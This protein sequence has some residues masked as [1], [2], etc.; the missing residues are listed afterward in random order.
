M[1]WLRLSITTASIFYTICSVPAMI[2]P[3]PP[4]APGANCRV[5]REAI[6]QA[7]ARVLDSGW[8]V[9][10][11]EVAA[12]EEEFAG[13]VGTRHAI[14]VG[15]GTD[16]L[17]V[18]LRALG[19]GPNDAVLTVSHTAV[20]TVAAIE[21]TGATPVLLDVD[22]VTFT[23]DT[24]ALDT[25]LADWRADHNLF[26]GAAPR[27]IIPVH[28]Y[29]HPADMPEIMRVAH[30]NGLAVVED[31]AQAH[32]ATLNGRR[33]GTWGDLA[34]FSFYPT[35][36]LSAIGDGGAVVT[37]DREL[38]TRCLQLRE[39]GWQQRSSVIPGMN[40]RLDELQAAILRIKL[41]SLETENRRRV[42]IAA[43]YRH[44]LGGV[45]QVPKSRA[46]ADVGHVYHQFVIRSHQ[47]DELKRR[48]REEYGVVT[49]IHY[50][51]AIHQQ[52][53][54]SGRSLTAGRHL[55]VTESLCREILSLPVFPELEDGDL[56]RVCNAVKSIV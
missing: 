18:A 37:N 39:Y 23:I 26:G 33:V 17:V 25:V 52:P 1:H 46:D 55:D 30:A 12:F 40:S 2:D 3:I 48:L 38:A 10:G 11:E 50:P 45:V 47:R 8:Y 32:G 43:A 49:L 19:I 22:P 4:T 21:L 9:L 27:A 54:Y 24:T 34:T 29:G 31:C 36:N 53:A 35:K 16:A 56:E 51:R 44:C 14:G 28:L 41:G 15:S 6:N 5:H 13:F 20:A 42:E 7:I